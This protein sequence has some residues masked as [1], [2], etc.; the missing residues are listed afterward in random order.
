MIP[1]TEEFVM[2]DVVK[3]YIV[4]PSVSTTESKFISIE[5]KGLHVWP[6]DECTSI[7]Y[8]FDGNTRTVV[9]PCAKIYSKKSSQVIAMVDL[10]KVHIPKDMKT[11]TDYYIYSDDGNTTLILDRY[12]D[13]L[14][15]VPLDV[16]IDWLEE[17]LAKGS[18]YRR[19]KT[20]LA[21]AK[22]CVGLYDNPTVLLYGY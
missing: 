3:M 20:A 17:E 19:F 15:Q 10:C 16:M 11:P 22:G 14:T 4:E 21:L 6:V 5:G 7:H 13:E 18:E 2:G 1:L 12:D 8:G 9:D